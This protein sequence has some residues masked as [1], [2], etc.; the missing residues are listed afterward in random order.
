MAKARV[1]RRL[2]AILAADVVGYSRLI[3]ADEEGT[4]ERLRSLHSE[5]IRPKIAADGGRIVKTSGD[6]ILVEFP[7]AV[8]AV[9]NALDI[10]EAMHRRNAEVAEDA[11]IVFRVGINVGDVIVEG[12]DIHGDGVNVAARLE[13]LAE[14]GNVYVSSTVYDQAA[15]KLAAAFDDL[16]EQTVKNISHPIRVFRARLEG[17]DAKGGP[18]IGGKAPHA[19][20]RSKPSIAVLPFVN[21]SGDPEQEYFADGMVDEIITALSRLRWLLVTARTSSFEFKGQAVDIREIARRLN[22]HYVLE[23]SVRKAGD[24]VR[25]IGQL[26][27]GTSGDH[28][29]ADRF[30]GQL[31]D[32][33]DLQDRITVSVVCAIEPSLRSAEIA[34]AKRKRPEN[35]GAYDYYLRALPHFYASTHEDSIEGLRL[36]EKALELDS[37]FALANAL[38][39]W[40]YFNLVTHRWAENPMDDAAK[41]ISLARAALE[42]EIDDPTAMAN[43]GWVLATLAHDLDAGLAAIDGAIKLG[44]NSAYAQSLGGWVMTF[45]G[46]QET[47]LNRLNEALRLSPSDP[48][49]YRFLTGAAVAN[50]LM[51]RFDEAVSFG[52]EARRR[53]TRWGPT[54]RTLAA[55]YAQL[56]QLDKAKEALAR[57]LEREPSATISHYRS[58]LPYR[59]PEQAEKLWEGLRKAGLPE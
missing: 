21:M 9:R 30:D 35:L 24:R 56:G 33:F 41:G 19:D 25:I 11:R 13:G 40:F 55:A 45:V 39:A 12:D 10:Q 6:G 4:R 32:V 23:G 59:I 1:Q 46:D 52:E 38:A 20:T 48:L 58:R 44:P 8:D 34:R 36:I 5:L 16:G 15:G 49:A 26:I 43:A 14:P 50:L 18:I 2:A 54:F 37:G 51:G 22:V 28:L 29:W 27:D 57:L 53:Q 47:A 42:A 7:S 31:A 17:D 3:E